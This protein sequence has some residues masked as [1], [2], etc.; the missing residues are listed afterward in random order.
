[1][2]KKTS[3]PAELSDELLTECEAVLQ[4]VF[5]NRD[6]LRHC[7]T[8]SSAATV[9]LDSNERLEFL[10][11]AILGVIVCELLFLRFPESAEGDLTRIKSVIVS[12]ITCARCATK[13]DMERF[14]L[15][16][17][18]TA[19]QNRVPESILA[20]VFEAI[21]GG[22]YLDGGFEAVKQF[23]CRIVA[24]EFDQSVESASGANFKSMLQT[25]SQ[26]T[27]G[28]TPLYA[29]LDEKGPDHSKCFKVCALVGPRVFPP[30]WG[31]NKKEAEQRAANNALAQ[32]EG[33]EAPFL[34]E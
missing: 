32:M 25:H 17:K 9:R 7:L 27:F 10:G 21:V 18:G 31:P 5:R 24:E 13:L 22:I 20:C 23:V 3:T 26:K 1:M 30:A 14:L 29:V 34:S 33:R 28:E 12:R 2:S 16:G 8:H 4:Y 19:I 15:L 11:D 6:L